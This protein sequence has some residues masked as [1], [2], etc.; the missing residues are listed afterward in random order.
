M[1]PSRPQ[2]FPFQAPHLGVGLAL[3]TPTCC[4]RELALSRRSWVGLDF[5][6]DASAHR[7]LVLCSPKQ[8]KGQPSYTNR[9][10]HLRR[11]QVPLPTEAGFAE[12]MRGMNEWQEA[13]GCGG[14]LSV[15][16]ITP[17]SS[18]SS[19]FC[20]PAPLLSSLFTEPREGLSRGP[21]SF[22]PTIYPRPGKQTFGITPETQY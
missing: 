4:R 19:S 6:H 17:V 2:E 9:D 3:P 10:F 7:V 13:E 12:Q 11:I 15:Q 8:S 5:F 22:I 14:L 21:S 16:T 20:S 1:D 18:S